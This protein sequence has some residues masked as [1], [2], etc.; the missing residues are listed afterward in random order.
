MKKVWIGWVGFVFAAGIASAAQVPFIINPVL[1][2]STVDGVGINEASVTIT[3]NASGNDLVYSFTYENAD[4]DGGGQ[5]NDTLSW[6]L[7]VEGFTGGV[8]NGGTGMFRVGTTPAQVVAEVSQG[9]S[10]G[11]AAWAIREALQFSVTNIVLTADVGSSV[12][13]DG[14]ESM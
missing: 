3:T 2:G 9:W 13:F 5:A 10:V 4:L 8:I 11:D 1:A 14:F 6:E 12:T 7:R